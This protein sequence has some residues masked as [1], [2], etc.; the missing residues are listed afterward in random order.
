MRF[1]ILLLTASACL[2]S[3]VEACSIPVF[4]YALEHWQPDP[5]MVAVFSQGELTTEQQALLERLDVRDEDGNPIANIMVKVIDV[6]TESNPGLLRLWELQKTDTLP[7][8][9]VHAPARSGPPQRIISGELTS[10]L[11]DGLLDSPE[12]R[13]AA[14]RLIAGD[15]VVWVFLESG[16]A[17]LD[18][19]TYE[20]LTDELARLETTLRLPEIEEA[21]FGDLSVVPESLRLAFSAIRLSRDDPAES[22]FVSMLLHADES[23]AEESAPAG[24]MAFPLFGRGRVLYALSGER[25]ERQSIE[26]ACRFLTGACQCTV[27]GENPGLDLLMAVDWESQ[28]EPAVP[29]DESQPPLVGLGAFVTGDAE[30][31]QADDAESDETADSVSTDAATDS[32]GGA[33]SDDRAGIAPTATPLSGASSSDSETS[34]LWTSLLLMSFVTVLGLATIILWRVKPNL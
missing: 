2:V 5:F 26:D 32:S 7:W 3:S 11:V 20:M 15:S 25:M 24:P 30:T 14:R 4:R 1:R 9:A 10:E 8:I 33:A 19:S 23:P 6:E 21:D 16:D 34:H 18:R 31:D 17:A 12:R 29:V 28:I 22:A 13:E 27:K